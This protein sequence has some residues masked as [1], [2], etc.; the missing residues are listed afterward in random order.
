VPDVP[1][2]VGQH[3]RTASALPSRVRGLAASENGQAIAMAVDEQLWIW[4][5][6]P[7]EV[8]GIGFWTD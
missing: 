2:V 7:E 8:K 4:Q 6:Y 3:N 5:Q 1:F